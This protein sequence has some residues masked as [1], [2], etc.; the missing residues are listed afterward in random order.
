[1]SLTVSLVT[2]ERLLWSGPA[3]FVLARTT[4]G[5]MGILKGHEPVLAELADGAVV[6]ITSEGEGLVTAAV[7][8]GFLSV[9]HDDVILLAETAELAEEIDAARAE[10][11]LERARA[12]ET[13]LVVAAA[14]RAEA[15]LRAVSGL[16]GGVHHR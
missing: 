1:M 15:R 12:A 5:D 11:A 4:E 10:R 7:H 13:S 14:H 3:T 8:G 6:R 9:D 2:A 16:R